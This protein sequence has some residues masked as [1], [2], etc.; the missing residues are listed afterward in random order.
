MW[1][2]IM[3]Y[4]GIGLV[5]GAVARFTNSSTSSLVGVLGAG[6]AGG[7]IGGIIANVIFSDEMA[8]DTAGY[9]GS[10]VLAIV[11]VLVV[12]IA[13]RTQAEEAVTSSPATPPPPPEDM[14]D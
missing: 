10:A 3:V 9:V 5:V 14:G 2:A 7:A 1:A 6:G 4:I 13:D 8:L 11:A 12:R